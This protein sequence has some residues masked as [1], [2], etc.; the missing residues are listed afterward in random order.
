ML[1][2]SENMYEKIYQKGHEGVEVVVM[3]VFSVTEMI[4]CCWY[5]ERTD[6]IANGELPV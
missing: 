2:S 4:A 3:I 5:L 6:T 1:F